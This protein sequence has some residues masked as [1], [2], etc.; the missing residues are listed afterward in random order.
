MKNA[1]YSIGLLCLILLLSIGF[2]ASYRFQDIHASDPEEEALEADNP[3][4]CSYH[5]GIHEGKVIVRL[6][7]GSIYET[8][9]IPWE[10]LPSTVQEQIES[11]YILE[12][13]QELYSFLEN[14]SS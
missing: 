9:E 3:L 13:K 4:R 7:D 11:G 8:T 2:Y 12:T 10:S 5:I 1:A 14:Y 6:D